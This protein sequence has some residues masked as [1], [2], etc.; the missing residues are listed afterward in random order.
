MPP[1]PR[2]QPTS[3]A[4]GRPKLG[5]VAREVT[6]L[7]R[8]WDWLS[9]QTGGASV[10]LPKLVEEARRVNAGRDVA[11]QSREAA[12]KFLSAIAGSLDSFEEATRALFAGELPRFETL[13][14]SW[15]VKVRDHASMLARDSFDS[16]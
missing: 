12:Y 7:P 6:L 4:R 2:S 1:L 5:V 14:S 13:P 10:A 16:N 8:H 11:R 9:S 15:P 3:R